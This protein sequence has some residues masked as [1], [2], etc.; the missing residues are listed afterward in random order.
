MTVSSASSHVK[1]TNTQQHSQFSSEKLS[2]A[3]LNV[4]GLRRRLLY[5]EFSDLVQNYD[6]FCLSET[7]LL[8]TDIISCPGYTFLSQPRRQ[9]FFRRSGG[10]GCLVRNNIVNHVSIIESKMLLL[11]RS[12]FR[13]SNQDSIRKMN[14]TSLNKK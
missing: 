13:H 5:T 9:L 10:T 3:S 11:Q 4:C 12:T 2:V 7:K 6:I 8:D 14:M 1:K